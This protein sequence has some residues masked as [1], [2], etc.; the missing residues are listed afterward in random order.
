MNGHSI[1]GLLMNARMVQAFSTT[2]NPET[3]ACGAY[4]DTQ[5]GTLSG[6][7]VNLSKPCRSAQS[8]PGA[9]P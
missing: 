8:R 5:P 6:T 9:L 3:R 4:P 2:L 7:R 1:E